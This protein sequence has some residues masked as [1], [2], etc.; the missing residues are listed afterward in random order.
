MFKAL[1][2]SLVA[3]ALL[4]TVILSTP[5]FAGMVSTPKQAAADAQREAAKELL[6]AR[7]TESGLNGASCEE[8]LNKLSTEDL[9]V[10]AGHVQATRNAGGVGIAI[11]V[12]AAVVV[13][14][15]VVVLETFYPWK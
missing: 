12:A 11:A 9:T 8:Q 13:I 4:S 6:K 14:V 7:L 15:V 5:A 10:L 1:R 3:V 2:S